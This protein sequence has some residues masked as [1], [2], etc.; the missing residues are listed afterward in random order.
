MSEIATEPAPVLEGIELRGRINTSDA[1]L[2]AN[3]AHSIRLGHP[4]VGPQPLQ[5]DRVVLVGGGPSLLDTF[6]ELRELYFAGAKVVTVNGSYAWCLERNIRPSA[7]VVLDARAQ[8]ARF[9]SPDVPQCRYLLASQCHPDTWAAVEGREHVRIWHAVS[10]E[11]PLRDLLDTYY[12]G[13]WQPVPGGTTVIMRAL[14]VMRTLGFLRFDLFGVDSCFLGGAHHAYAQPE[15]DADRAV[16]VTV[17]PTGE[18]DKGRTFHCAPWHL[19]Q[20]E[21]FLHTVR[22]NGDQFLLNVH[23]DGLLAYALKASADVEWSAAV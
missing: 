6:D 20:F 15:N 16:A 21:D 4:Q 14:M 2:L 19:K 17:H 5:R 11:G 9:V 3:I 22:L 13:R 1:D 23:G 18:P 10:E 7:Q 8:N 12:A